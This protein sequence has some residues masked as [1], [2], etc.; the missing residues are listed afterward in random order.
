M[1]PIHLIPQQ[2][3]IDFLRYKWIAVGFTVFLTIASIFIVATRGLNY[4]IDFA[5]GIMMEVS[6]TDGSKVELGS[7]REHLNGIGLGEVALQEFGTENHILIRVQQQKG[8]QAEQMAAVQKS[9][10]IARREIRFPPRRICRPQSWQRIGARFDHRGIIVDG[11]HHAV[12]LVPIRMAVWR[13]RLDR[14][15]L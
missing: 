12:Y 15:Y 6:A 3:N 9:A 13:Q 4:G 14:R 1:L 11:R 5:G 10:R 8:G 2:P 7:M